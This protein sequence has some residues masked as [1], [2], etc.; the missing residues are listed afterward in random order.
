MKPRNTETIRRDVLLEASMILQ[1]PSKNTRRK[2]LASLNL[3]LGGIL[4]LHVLVQLATAGHLVVPQRDNLVFPTLIG[5]NLLS[6]LYQ[7]LCLTGRRSPS[8]RWDAITRWMTILLFQMFALVLL[9]A[10]TNSVAS[11]LFD[12]ALGVLMIFLT[13]FVL[14]RRAAVVWCLIHVMNFG[15]A[16]HRIG[17]GFII[18]LMT[19]QE[20]AALRNLQLHDGAAYAS[21]MSLAHA[22]HIDPL[23]IALCLMVGLIYSLLSVLPTYFESSMMAQVL[24]ALP[25]AIDR[26]QIASKQKQELEKENLRLGT[27]LE[28]AQRIQAMILPKPEELAAIEGLEVAATMRPATEVGGDLYDVLPC[29][30]GITYLVI[31]DVTDHG[32]ASGVV[33]LMAQAAIRSCLETTS[34]GLCQT[35]ASV[36]SLIYNNVQK[37][38]GDFRNLTLSLLQHQDGH[39]KIAGQHECVILLRHGAAT[40][41][42]INTESLGFFVGM[43]DNIETMVREIQVEFRP[44]DLLVLHTDG[45]TEAENAAKQQFGLD[46]LIEAL[47]AARHKSP[48]E[49]VGAL[50][51]SVSD[52]MG[53]APMFDD[54]TLVVVRKT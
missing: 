13:G 44:G 5:A 28:V 1:E 45:V 12:N 43:V 9:H 7:L 2:I 26:I 29:P 20:V 48:K 4:L 16:I 41:E 32:L 11:V 37:R 38:M 31:G 52:W 40:A 35:L 42:V 49:I 10:T 8:P 25:T 46:R 53:S 34:A 54:I 19:S 36:N 3:V 24:G 51:Q 22:E 15:Y 27:E 23:P 50:D 30:N 6:A 47:I 17:N 14:G 39:L 21:R 33:M 18:M